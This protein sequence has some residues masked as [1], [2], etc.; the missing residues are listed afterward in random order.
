MKHC[1]KCHVVVAPFEPDKVERN[2]QVYHHACAPKPAAVQVKVQAN[3][4]GPNQSFFR[5]KAGVMV[6]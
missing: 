2:G 5:F 3:H 1:P 4:R 6:H